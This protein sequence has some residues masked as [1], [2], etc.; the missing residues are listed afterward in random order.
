MSGF[1]LFTATAFLAAQGELVSC[2][3]GLDSKRQITFC[4]VNGSGCLLVCSAMLIDVSEDL[5][6][7][8]RG[9]ALCSSETSVNMCQSA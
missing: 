2:G 7:S 9:S 3:L 4:D 6:S 1:Y 8:I 5:T